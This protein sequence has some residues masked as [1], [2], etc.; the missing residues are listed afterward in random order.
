MVPEYVSVADLR[1]AISEELLVAA[2]VPR[3]G[4]LQ[5]LLRPLL[6]FPAHR[7]ATLAAEFDRRVA[8]YGLAE[9]MRWL[10]WRFVDDVCVYGQEHIPASGPLVVVSNHPG[11]YDIL[12]IGAHLGRDD[13]R[14]PASDVSLLR[15]LH[16]TAEYLIYTH[17]GDDS[18][19][20]IS[21]AR[22]SVRHLRSGGALLVYAA[23]KVEPDPAVLPGAR[24]GL[25]DWLD[26]PAWLLRQVPDAV[27]VV[28]IVSN[29][30]SP[31]CLRSPL[32]YLRRQPRRKQFLAEAAQIGQQVLFGRRF[33]LVPE[34]RFG[35]PLSAAVLGA[36]RNSE[37]ARTIILEQ[38]ERLLSE[39]QAR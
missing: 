12:A 24:A 19:A 36:G 32:T 16:G 2:G 31:S 1:R 25:Q 9:G 11:S 14:I 33:S 23:S 34:V 29:V 21:A 4:L 7:F 22:D 5:A 8:L 27:L 30:L 15:Q 28:T 38:A 39:A 20:R 10:L 37:T 13:L 18:H 35:L 17:L 3:T 26:S 6:W